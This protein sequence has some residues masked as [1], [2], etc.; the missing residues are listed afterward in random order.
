MISLEECAKCAELTPHEMFFGVSPSPRHK[1]LLES[2]L[3][4]LHH[5]AATVRN[6][7]VADIRG[8]VDLGLHRYAADALVA[9]RLFL[10]EHPEA[11]RARA[12][13]RNVVP[14]RVRKVKTS[15]VWSS[16]NAYVRPDSSKTLA[17]D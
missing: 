17:V 11:G 13:A 7:I 14:F 1:R 4:N 5:G 9:L 12:S 3:L 8:F 10:A 2:Y 16:L 15:S 6:M